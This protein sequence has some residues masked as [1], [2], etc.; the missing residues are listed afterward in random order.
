MTLFLAP[1]LCTLIALGLTAGLTWIESRRR[2]G[3][4]AALNGPDIG[5]VAPSP[6]ACSCC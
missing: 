4:P 2:V 5:T 3:L 6:S 1:A